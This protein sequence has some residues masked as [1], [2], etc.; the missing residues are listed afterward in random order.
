LEGV[1]AKHRESQYSVSATW[2]KNKN[3]NYCQ[4]ERRHELFNSYQS[5]TNRK[6]KAG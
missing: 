1:V 6:A 5:V 3:P 2:I 4:S